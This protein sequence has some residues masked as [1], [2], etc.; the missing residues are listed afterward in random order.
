MQLPPRTAFVELRGHRLDSLIHQTPR[1][2]VWRGTADDGTRV[3]VKMPTEATPTPREIAR[4]QWAHDLAAAADPRAVVRHLALLRTGASVALVME[5]VGGEPLAARIPPG[6]LPLSRWLALAI[7]LA[8]ALG[9]LHDSGLVHKDVKPHNVLVLPPRPDAPGPDVRLI[10]LGISIRLKRE[11]V[12]APALDQIEGTLAYMSP[13]QCGR[14]ASPVDARSDLYSLGVT[15]FEMAAGRLPFGDD[16]PA[17]LAHAHVARPPPPLRTL[18]PDVPTVVVAIVERLLAKNADDRYASAQ[19]LVHDLARCQ[20]ELLRSGTVRAFA[21]GQV[22]ANLGFRIPDRLYGREAERARLLAAVDQAAAGARVLV[23][24]AGASGIGKTALVNDMHKAV[25]AGRARVATGKF[26][27]FRDDLPY[28]GILKALRTLLKRELAEPEA[29]LAPRRAALREALGDYGALLTAGVP[30]LQA[31]VGPQPEVEAIA[32]QDAA[33]RLHRVAA[34]F[35]A[36]FATSEQ[37]LVLFLDDLQW[38]DPASLALIEALGTDP[39]LAHLL[40]VAGWRS[41]EVGPG[42]P[43]HA[44]LAPLRDA[45]QHCVEL[46]L[47]PLQRADVAALLADTLQAE[48]AQVE[49]LA[50]HVHGVAA[51]NPF[52]VAEFLLALRERGFFRHD[53]DGRGWVWDLARLPDIGLPDNV[54]ALIAERLVGLPAACLDLLDSAACVGSEFDLRTLASVHGSAQSAAAVGLAPAVRAGIVL[55]LDG[56]YKVFESLDGW[57]LPAAELGELGTA[58]YRFQHDRVRQTVHERLDDA[59]RAE[60]HLRIGR[61]LWRGLAHEELQQRVVEVF[62]HVVEGVALVSDAAERAELARLGLAAGQ[63]ALRALAFDGARR[64]LQAAAGLL[65]AEAWDA[66]HDTAVGLHLALAQCAYALT[67]FDAAEAEAAT[68]IAR[69]RRVA[70]AAE[71][72]G[73]RIRIRHT[74]NRYAEAVDVGVQVA[75]A[76]GVALPRKPRLPHVLAG[77]L[78]AVA[79]QRGRDPLDFAALGEAQDADMRAAVSLLCSVASPAYFSEPDLLPLIGITCTRLSIR[80]GLTPQSPYGFAVWALVLCGVLGRID[81]G[82]RFGELAL[83]V[84][85][86]YGGTDEARARFVVDTFIKHWKEPLPE[87]AHLLHGDWARSRDAGDAES[88]TYCAGVTLYTHF[89]AG[90]PLDQRERYGDAIA[91]LHDCEQPHVKDCF[92]AWVQLVDALRAPELPAELD[93]PAFSYPA[94]LPVFERSENRVQ[95]AISAIAAGL[96]DLFAG[97]HARAEARFALAARWER[98]IVGQVLVP[99]LAF[100]RALNAY[101]L[102]AAAGSA[103]LRRIARRQHARLARWAPLAPANLAHRLALLDAEAALLDGQT[104]AAIVRL[105]A[106]IQHAASG[107]GL[108]Y[109]ALAQQ[110]LAAVLAAQGAAASAATAALQAADAFSRWGAPGLADEVQ[111]PVPAAL[112]RHTTGGPSSSS[113]ATGAPAAALG[114]IDLQSLFA[115]VAAISSEIDEA[116]LLARLMPTLMQAAGA[117]RGLLLLRDPQGALWIE[118]EARLAGV[119]VQRVALAPLDAGDAPAPVPL[120]RRV[121]DLAQRSA[122]PVV[123]HD[124]AAAELLEGEAYAREQGVAALLALAIALQGRP[125]GVLYLENH[126]ARGAFTDSRVEIVRALGAQ[127]GIALEN[128]RL[129]GRVQ[130]ALDAQTVLTEANRRFVPREFVSG[131]GVQSIVDVRLN[132]AIER[133]MNVLFVDLRGFTQL[134]LTLGPKATVAVINRYLSHVQPGIAAHGG[135]V[136]QY[137]GDGVMALFPNDADDALR[138]ALAMCRGLEGYNRER[139]SDFPALAFGMGLHSGPLTLGTIGDPDHFQC[140]VVGDSVNLASRMEG[141]TKHFGATL[142]LSGATVERLKAPQSFLLRPLGRVEVA[143]R[144]QQLEVYEGAGSHAEEVQE[145]LAQSLPSYLQAMALYR[146]GRFAQARHGFEACAAA[147]VQD[148][149]AARFAQRCAGRADGAWDG[150]ERPAKG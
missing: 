110:R 112:R 129:Y 14:I 74:P 119:T 78:R 57:A 58:R 96:L 103:S 4:Y 56:K 39:A 32:P 40:L 95:I 92:L 11:T 48:R 18:R 10:D 37:P 36:V 87:I 17:E 124:A 60:R 116:A 50:V 47:P 71:A 80:H 2:S 52:F 13:E 63:R 100:F 79:A 61:L 88:A 26:D 107:G 67:R 135:F 98:N 118:V 91:F 108:L 90:S 130:S 109:E 20:A 123:V 102:A 25:A 149:V 99:G 133:E 131:L 68:V 140:G 138:G 34:R 30:E 44:S 137:Y 16:S 72:H 31:L 23:T 125:L 27:Q 94:L 51:G 84:G 85:R 136:G 77:V 132:V 33:R 42:H 113:S 104:G 76:L 15:L 120:S 43:L 81:T 55:P 12:E 83:Q 8:T 54:A 65:A 29:V 127:A 6:G 5:D 139:G 73:L 146:D 147:C 38:A 1:S 106:A 41:N 142:V 35:L 150:I 7:A 21:I 9:R 82:Y 128:A 144:R 114:G 115:A 86:R 62:M 22:D 59:R 53:A 89:L 117:D 111:A 141:L 75:A 143:G 69:A 28:L 45:A 64:M 97:R 70:D 134:T 126:V 49:A 148:S 122:E 105:H 121:V 93:G 66:D 46:L 3:V 24:V 19:G 145:R 101:R